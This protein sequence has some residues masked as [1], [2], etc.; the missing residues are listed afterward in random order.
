M[1]RGAVVKGF[2]R[3]SREL[4]IP[5]ANMDAKLLEEPLAKLEAGIYAGW[6]Q[7]EGYPVMKC[8]LSI[9]WNP[10]FKDVKEKT[11]EPHIIH[12]FPELFYG[13]DLRVLV[14]AYL[15]PE[16]DFSGLDA[17]IQTIKE[18][19]ELS[20]EQ[21][22]LPPLDALQRRSEFE[23]AVPP[24]AAAAGAGGAAAAAADAVDGGGPAASA[25]ARAQQPTSA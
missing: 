25:P 9:G 11:V 14:A 17:L 10:F 13:K 12:E 23:A 8:C 6:A 7:V 18:D 24:V 22:A 16:L 4:G 19:I 2:G 21:L 3:G 5:T 15:R 20:A 1:L